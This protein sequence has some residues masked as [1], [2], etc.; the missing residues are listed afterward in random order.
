[1]KT[2][3]LATVLLMAVGGSLQAKNNISLREMGTVRLDSV[4][5]ALTSIYAFGAYTTT[6]PIIAGQNIPVGAAIPYQGGNGGF[7]TKQTYTSHDH[8]QLQLTIDAQTLV[9]GD[10]ELTGR[11]TG[12][13]DHAGHALFSI[14]IGGQSY[15]VIFEVDTM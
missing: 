13:P 8:P 3:L 11:I 4:P 1:M 5:G 2:F 9:N 12:T 6:G 10:G 14:T 15:Y 7:I